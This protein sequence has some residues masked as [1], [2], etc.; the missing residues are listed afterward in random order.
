MAQGFLLL[1]VKWKMCSRTISNNLGILS[2]LEIQ[3]YGFEVWLFFSRN[4]LQLMANN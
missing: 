3:L 2:F 4:A 1:V